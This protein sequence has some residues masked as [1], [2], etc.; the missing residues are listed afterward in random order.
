MN[1]K[2]PITV[3]LKVA[4]TLCNM[5]CKYCYEQGED[6]YNQMYDINIL[7]EKILL[8]KKREKVLFLIHGGEPLLA[9]KEYIKEIFQ[10]IDINFNNKYLIQVQTNGTL[11]DDEWIEIFN[12]NKKISLSVSLDPLGVKDLRIANFDYRKKVI[13][14]LKKISS[15]I[16][17]VGVVSVAHKYNKN[18][19]IEFINE[20]SSIGIKSLTINKYKKI[21]DYDEAFISEF[22][23]VKLLIN[24]MNYWIK[25]NKYKNIRIQ[26]LIGLMSKKNKICTYLPDKNKCK[27]FRTLYPGEEKE[28]LC[29]HFDKDKINYDEI[30]NCENCE[31][32]S[33]CGGGCLAEEKTSDFCTARKYLFNFKENLKNGNKKINSQ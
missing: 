24:V 7:K 18:N 12:S 2:E 11:I 8:Y 26:P 25:S 9:G 29:D 1:N 30:K 6:K 10:F 20:L 28:I 4:G 19:F 22:E 15:E 17:N 16:E 3:M 21:L 14:N 31:I 33:F 13:F 32:Y 5:K 27:C 23:Y